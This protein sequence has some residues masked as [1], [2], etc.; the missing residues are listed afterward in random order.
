M[1]VRHRTAGAEPPARRARSTGVEG[2]TVGGLA[3][4]G[5]PQRGRNP[6]R[7]RRLL[8]LGAVAVMACVLFPTAAASAHAQLESTQP[9]QS[10][11]LITPP[12]QVVLHFG[13][14]VEID[15]GSIR[16]FG[17]T[18]KRVDN[19]GTHHPPGDSHSVAISLPAH[20][21]P[22]TYVVAW[23]VISAD[24]H[25]VHGA[26]VFSIGSARGSAKAG[27]LARAL[28][29]ASGS[30]LVGVVFWLVRTAIFTALILVVGVA[31]MITLLWPAG[32]RRRRARRVVWTAWAVEL[33]ATVASVA[34]QG[35]YA[36]TLPLT[37]IFRPSLFN[38]VLHTRLGEVAVVR[39]VLLIA[40][41]LVLRAVMGPRGAPAR[42]ALV[43]VG[44][45]LAVALLITPG[46]A[47]HASTSGSV[48]AGEG[49]DVAHLGAVSVWLG[50][51][52]V[53]AVLL[54]PGRRGGARGEEE[55]A[56]DGIGGDVDDDNE[57]WAVASR[58]LAFAFGGVVVVVASG[59]VQSIR[60][61]GSFYALFNTGYGRTLIVKVALVAVLVSVGGL[62]RRAVR[63]A[64]GGGR[65][66][67]R[68][69]PTATGN[70]GA[71]VAEPDVMR[72]ATPGRPGGDD[73]RVATAATGVGPDAAVAIATL[74]PEPT[75]VQRPAASV[76]RR[77]LRRTVAAELV[78]ALAVLAVT[79][80]LVNAVPAKQ[81]AEQPFSQTFNVL[82][83]QVNTIISPARAGPGNQFHFYVLGREGQPV[84]IPEL[85]ASIAL[86]S[87]GVGPISIPVEVA[88]PG[89]YQAND[90]DIPF[91]GTWQLILTVR[92]SAIDE[93][94]VYAKLLVR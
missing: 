18:G 45:V 66:R 31:T 68:F 8:L 75:S 57:L 86:P 54:F 80:L 65:R 82:G 39:V 69:A 55:I 53:L 16:V 49:L 83:V 19:G 35:V 70:P 38:E 92:T 36:A 40:F 24:T 13:E 14:P 73:R 67:R 64:A 4:W 10:A 7:V 42:R 32:W 84:A 79:A 62:S 91:A 47:G 11:V 60:Q 87:D 23:H 34:V 46:L 26:F 5:A 89:H 6:H 29:N 61:V 1:T 78:I 74:A 71:R 22:G 20:L 88:S 81:A 93:Q 90:V 30:V 3:V 21:G 85:D 59:V 27:V 76:G 56:P 12:R 94:P 33:V 48:W 41:G 43:A 15:F 50:G 9:S 37:D 25:P 72:P 77:A 2:G 52:S 51:L 17:P 63:R 58:F 44:G 28:Q